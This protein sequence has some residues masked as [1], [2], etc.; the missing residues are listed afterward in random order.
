MNHISEI[1]NEIFER[2]ALQKHTCLRTAVETHNIENMTEGLLL[3]AGGVHTHNEME[4]TECTMLLRKNGPGPNTAY[5]KQVHALMTTDIDRFHS[6]F[7]HR[8]WR[9]KVSCDVRY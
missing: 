7:N 4:G 8:N 5:R 1:M 9:A 3:S 6:I 2:H